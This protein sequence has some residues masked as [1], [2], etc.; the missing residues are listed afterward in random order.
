MINQLKKRP[1]DF[2]LKKYIFTHTL[3]LNVILKLIDLKHVT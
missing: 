3:F 1:D 2:F